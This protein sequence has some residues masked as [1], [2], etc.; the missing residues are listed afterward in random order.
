M[1][2]VYAIDAAHNLEPGDQV[3]C[4]DNAPRT[5]SE[6]HSD[7]SKIYVEYSNGIRRWYPTANDDRRSWVHVKRALFAG[8]PCTITCGADCYPG[9]VLS[10]TPGGASVMV[11]RL[12]TRATINGVGYLFDA[13]PI[14]KLHK[15]TRRSTLGG[16]YFLAGETFS[17]LSFGKRVHYHDP[18]F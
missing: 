9:T 12:R 10:W 15:F 18:H 17:S 2:H 7:D 14:G 8:M 3:V 4:G 13:E 5:V 11:G 1:I 16:R 6:I